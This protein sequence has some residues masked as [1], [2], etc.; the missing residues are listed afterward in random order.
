[1]WTCV[2]ICAILCAHCA[3]LHGGRAKVTLCA[4]CVWELR[5][6]DICIH[7]TLKYP[8][9]AMRENPRFFSANYSVYSELYSDL[10]FP[11]GFTIPVEFSIHANRAQDKHQPQAR[12]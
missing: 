9:K 1:M 11:H 4:I 10:I 6:S 5:I 3:Y 2:L 7:I 8:D 12:W